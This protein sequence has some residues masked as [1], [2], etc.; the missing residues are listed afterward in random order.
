MLRWVRAGDLEKASKLLDETRPKV[1]TQL[2]LIADEL[3]ELKGID[4]YIAHWRRQLAGCLCAVVCQRMAQTVNGQMREIVRSAGGE[5]NVFGYTPGNAMALTVFTNGAKVHES[6]LD[7]Y[8]RKE[9][10][11]GEADDRWEAYVSAAGEI[12]PRYFPVSH[13]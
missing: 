2:A 6:F 9:T 4:D 10:P 11:V 3:K 13:S 1:E 12:L 5:Y 8:I 7:R